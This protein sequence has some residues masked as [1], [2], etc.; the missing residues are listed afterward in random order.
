M[1]TQPLDPRSPSPAV[2]CA[3]S[4]PKTYRFGQDTGVS[5]MVVMALALWPLG[6]KDCSPRSKPKGKAKK[7]EALVRIATSCGPGSE[8]RRTLE[9]RLPAPYPRG[10]SAFASES[11]ELRA[12]SSDEP[13]AALA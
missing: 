13:R 6:V 10:D 1:G 12:T 4:K 2:D 3:R 11:A 5:A 8:N 7:K 9:R